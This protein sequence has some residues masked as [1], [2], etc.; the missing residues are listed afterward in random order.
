MGRRRG[1]PHPPRIPHH[2]RPHRRPR[3][4]RQGLNADYVLDY[5]NHKL[6]VSRPRRGTSSSPRA[7]LRPRTTPA[8]SPSA[9]PTATNGQ[10]IYG[11]DMETGK[12]GELSALP[13][14]PTNSGTAPLPS[15]THGATVSPPCPSRI[16]SG[17]H[18]SRYYQDIAVER[19]M[20]AIAAKHAAHP[21]HARD[22]HRQDLHRV[23]DRMEAVSSPLEPEPR[24][25]A[26]PAHPV[27]R[28]PQHPRQPG[29]QRLLRLSR[30]RDGADQRRRTSA[31]RARCRR[32]ATCS[33]PSSR[34]S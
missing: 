14:R 15:R 28:R 2:A 11:I 18:P 6:A 4:A 26:P 27:P 7:W 29:L 13:R 12:E 8:S 33:S 1:Q 32:T 10:G 25:D 22:R 19:V 20:E 5:R 3:Q 24:T 31:R 9:S 17:S 30:R 21:A 23:P 34:P 16:K